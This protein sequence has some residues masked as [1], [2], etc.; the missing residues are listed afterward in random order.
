MC[1]SNASDALCQSMTSFLSQQDRHSASFH[2]YSREAGRAPRGQPVPCSCSE[3]TK[4]TQTTPKTKVGQ[5]GAA[6]L[7]QKSVGSQGSGSLLESDSS[8]SGSAAGLAEQGSATFSFECTHFS[9]PC[10][11]ALYPFITTEALG[12]NV[13]LL[14]PSWHPS[15]PLQCIPSGFLIARQPT[16]KPVLRLLAEVLW[17]MPNNALWSGWARRTL[18]LASL[19]VMRWRSGVWDREQGFKFQKFC[20]PDMSLQTEIWCAQ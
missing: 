11:Y 16:R 19:Q 14:C 7:S 9:I 12:P 15:T 10:M 6:L 17:Y 2:H 13:F 1:R 4:S 20:P 3:W 8:T 5:E 18:P